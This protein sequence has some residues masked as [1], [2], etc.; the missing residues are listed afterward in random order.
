MANNVDLGCFP[1]LGIKGLFFILLALEIGFFVKHLPKM[2]C[3]K[4]QLQ[5]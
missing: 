3:K 2:S 5:F 1:F 4:G